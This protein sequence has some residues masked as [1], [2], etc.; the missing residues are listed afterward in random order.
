MR[1]ATSVTLRFLVCN[2]KAQSSTGFDHSHLLW[3][4]KVAN[5][6]KSSEPCNPRTSTMARIKNTASKRKRG[7]ER[8]NDDVPA[9]KRIT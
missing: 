1:Q 9:A 5:A 2:T 3:H 6:V 7:D 4:P 8:E